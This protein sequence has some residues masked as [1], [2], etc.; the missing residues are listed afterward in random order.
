MREGGWGGRGGGGGE[1]GRGKR[2]GDAVGGAFVIT[3]LLVMVFV[4]DCC[5]VVFVAHFIV[6]LF[7][8]MYI[9]SEL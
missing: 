1:G 7:I 8:S 9:C 4:C 6:C 3:L 2:G 5:T